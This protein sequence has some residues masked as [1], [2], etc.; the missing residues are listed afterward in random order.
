MPETSVNE[1]RNF[2]ADEHNIGRAWQVAP[3][4]SEPEAVRVQS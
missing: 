4:Q 3:V 2:L 1:D